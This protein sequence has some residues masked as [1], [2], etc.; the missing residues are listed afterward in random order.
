MCRCHAVIAASLSLFL[1]FFSDLI[2][3]GTHIM[4]RCIADFYCTDA[5][6]VFHYSTSQHEI[7]ILT[8][9]KFGH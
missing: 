3:I 2:I 8:L 9:C 7:R 1:V 4:L 5:L 6:L